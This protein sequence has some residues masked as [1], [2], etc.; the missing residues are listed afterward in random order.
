MLRL[1]AAPDPF[2]DRIESSNPE[3]SATRAHR[4]CPRTA[5]VLLIPGPD[6]G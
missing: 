6:H 3:L 4:H 5:T 1:I 2:V